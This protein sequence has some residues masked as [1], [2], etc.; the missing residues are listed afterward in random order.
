MGAINSFRARF[1]SDA[2]LAF[3]FRVFFRCFNYVGRLCAEKNQAIACLAGA[4]VTRTQKKKLVMSARQPVRDKTPP[5]CLY[6]DLSFRSQQNALHIYKFTMHN[7]NQT[8]IFGSGT[9]QTSR[10]TKAKKE[11]VTNSFFLKSHAIDIS[12]DY[13]LF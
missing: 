5:P 13:V 4:S 11:N 9:V 6:T 1:K 2:S 7:T 8:E 12:P 10:S 3:H